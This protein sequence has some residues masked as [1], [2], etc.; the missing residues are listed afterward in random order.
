M[1]RNVC[2]TSIVFLF[3]WLPVAGAAGPDVSA[4]NRGRLVQAYGRL[5]MS[6]EA[7]RG[8]TDPRVRFLGRG[9]SYTL[10]LTEDEAVLALRN[11][12]G[13]VAVRV[14]P[15]G[16]NPRTII[17]GIDELPGR[18]NYFIGTDP[19]QWHTG[20]PTYAAVK[21]DSVYPGIDLIYHGSQGQ[22]EYDF[23]LNPGADPHVIE[24]S[25]PGGSKLTVNRS[26]ELIIKLAGGELIE[27]APV[28]FQENGGQRHAVEGRYVLR[29]KGRVGFR[30]GNYDRSRPLVID[31]TLV[32]STYLGGSANDQANSIAID[33]RGNTYITGFAQSIDFPTTMDA[34]QPALKGF[35]NVFVSKMNPAGSALLY[36]TYLGGS[37]SDT[38]LG[39]AVDDSG[40]AYVT[41]STR[42]SDFPTTPG[43]FQRTFGGTLGFED[44][45]VNSSLGLEKEESLLTTR[46]E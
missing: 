41:G 26:G 35:A 38:G 14:K 42:S 45:F 17:S 21:Y 7:N 15:V 28:I 19:K 11:S 46:I 3:L 25:F 9:S 12:D 36:S 29:G 32:Y 30:L 33:T 39:I 2:I 13:N 24:L 23:R 20:V 1:N 6:F 34:Y 5:P 10:F 37:G 27:H 4:V 18:S 43:A 44:A 31:P 16:A 40:N 8:Q 22:L